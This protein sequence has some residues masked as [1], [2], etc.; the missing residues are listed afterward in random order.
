[1]RSADAPHESDEH[2]IDS[3]LAH[4]QLFI[5][6]RRTGITYLIE[7]RPADAPRKSDGTPYRQTAVSQIRNFLLSPEAQPR[8]TD[9][10]YLIEIRPATQM[11]PAELTNTISMY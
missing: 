6:P 2:H 11:R 7:I 5:Q 4:P 10:T 3:R 8:R 1:M 9:I